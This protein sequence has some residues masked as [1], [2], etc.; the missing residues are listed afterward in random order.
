MDTAF[1]TLKRLGIRTVNGDINLFTDSLNHF[2]K[3]DLVNNKLLYTGFTID[4]FVNRAYWSYT[5]NT[6]S[7]NGWMFT[8]NGLYNEAFTTNTAWANLTY[9]G[10][11]N[12]NGVLYSTI[13][14][15]FFQYNSDQFSLTLGRQRINWGIHFVWQPNDIFNSFNYLDFNYPERPGSDAL[16]LQ[17]YTSA[18]SSVDI[19]YKIN[20][21]NQSTFGA[22]YAFNVWNYD[23]QT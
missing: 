22:K 19:A 3:A 11:S 14:R 6:D 21:Q 20:A 18:T 9:A 5:Y 17:Y 1:T 7:K 12:D 23:F 2:Y 4:S 15:L 16:R 13:D 10:Y 8:Q